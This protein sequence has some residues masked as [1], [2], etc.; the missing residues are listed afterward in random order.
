MVA[1]IL[2][3][4]PYAEE[5]IGVIWCPFV[6]SSFAPFWLRSMLEGSVCYFIL[7]VPSRVFRYTFPTQNSWPVFIEFMCFLLFFLTTT[8]GRSVLTEP[9]CVLAGC[10]KQFRFIVL[11]PRIMR[12]FA[13]VAAASLTYRRLSLAF[14]TSRIVN[15]L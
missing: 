3:W 12:S 6:E 13:F 15:F 4:G 2:L 5:C 7:I 1:S 11:F 9:L 10:R 14:V 8:K